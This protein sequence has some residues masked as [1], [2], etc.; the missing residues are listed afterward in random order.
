MHVLCGRSGR[1]LLLLLLPLPRSL[2]QLSWG[3]SRMLLLL[4]PL[5]AQAPLPQMVHT[6]A[7]VWRPPRRGPCHRLRLG[8]HTA[9]VWLAA[10]ILP[11]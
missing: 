2:R 8:N 3:R 10:H 7:R 6:L 4:P 5:C 11:A 9:M 1:L